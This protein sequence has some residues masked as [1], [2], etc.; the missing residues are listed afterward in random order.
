MKIR[1]GKKKCPVRSEVELSCFDGSVYTSRLSDGSRRPRGYIHFPC[2]CRFLLPSGSADYDYTPYTT[3]SDVSCK[4]IPIPTNNTVTQEAFTVK[5]ECFNLMECAEPICCLTYTT[6]STVHIHSFHK[7]YIFVYTAFTLSYSRAAGGAS[8]R[9]YGRPQNTSDPSRHYVSHAIMQSPAV[10]LILPAQLPGSGHVTSL[11]R[12]T[13]SLSSTSQPLVSVTSP[14]LSLP[15]NVHSTECHRNSPADT[16]EE[17]EMV[18]HQLVT[19]FIC[20]RPAV[21][22]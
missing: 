5:Y 1:K 7:K 13:P 6:C 14:A 3:T 17:I 20:A 9:M 15:A 10:C 19:H 4:N 12:P 2:N 11:H 18:T 16:W 21:R 22:F 8:S